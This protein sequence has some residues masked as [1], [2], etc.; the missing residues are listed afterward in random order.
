M[1]A[2]HWL[3]LRSSFR[4]LPLQNHTA[5]GPWRYGSLALSDCL[6]S[7]S[8]TP[9]LVQSSLQQRSANPNAIHATDISGLN[10]QIGI[11]SHLQNERSI[12]QAPRASECGRSSSLV[13]G[14]VRATD[15]E[16]A[17]VLGDAHREDILHLKVQ[18]SHNQGL[19][20]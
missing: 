12:L 16:P 8:H 6:A 20:S 4:Q 5:E 18:G 1:L 17:A 13:V 19:A 15:S 9:A 11:Q 3:S 7:C 14:G 10:I 2:C